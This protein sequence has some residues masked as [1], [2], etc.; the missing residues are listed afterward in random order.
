MYRFNKTKSTKRKLVFFAKPLVWYLAFE[1]PK[2]FF[3]M[4]KMCSPWLLVIKG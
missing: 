1:K 3:A 2:I 4:R